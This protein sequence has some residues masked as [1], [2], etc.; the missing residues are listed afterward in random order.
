MSANHPIKTRFLAAPEFQ[1]LYTREY[2]NVYD[3]DG[4]T[5]LR[6]WERNHGPT[7]RPQRQIVD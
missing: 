2:A 3:A 7:D 4:W 6:W 1:A 5:P